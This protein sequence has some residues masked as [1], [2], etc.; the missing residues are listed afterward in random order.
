MTFFV[1]GTTDP[2]PT[3]RVPR[4]ARLRVVLTNNDPGY[5]HNLIV[6]TFGIETALIVKGKS[7]TIEMSVPLAPG[8]HVY[9]CGPHAE[10][11]R[12]NIAVE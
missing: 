12:G 9:S 7:Q 6:P 11:M 10:M 1:E 2:N 8:M 3:I 4:G 5:S